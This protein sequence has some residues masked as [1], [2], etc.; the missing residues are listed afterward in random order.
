MGEKSTHGS[1]LK[2]AQFSKKK[3]K[4]TSDL[5]TLHSTQLLLQ[6]DLTDHGWRVRSN[7][8]AVPGEVGIGYSFYAPIFF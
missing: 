1:S 5:T 2:V 4:K 3:K 8:V 6:S 7:G